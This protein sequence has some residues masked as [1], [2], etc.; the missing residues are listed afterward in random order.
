MLRFILFLPILFLIS[1]AHHRDVR[2]GVD[3]VHRV[4]VKLDEDVQGSREALGQAD[5]YCESLGKRA[6]IISE[7]KKY[8]GDMKEEDYKKAKTAT[9]VVGAVGG[10]TTIFGGRNERKAGWA[11]ALGA[12]AADG[13]IGM[14]YTLELK[15]KCL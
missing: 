2:P 9:K 1:C 10:L 3:G 6:A 7:E 4:V 11:T 5:H 13:I 14:G 15:F 8:T 12:S